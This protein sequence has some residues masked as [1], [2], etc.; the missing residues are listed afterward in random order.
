MGLMLSGRYTVNIWSIRGTVD[1]GRV[2]MQ[3]VKPEYLVDLQCGKH[4]A[5]IEVDYRWD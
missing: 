5:M 4:L 1:I 2:R 3:R